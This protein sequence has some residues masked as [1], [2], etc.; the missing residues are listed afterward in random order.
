MNNGIISKILVVFGS[1]ALVIGAMF[2]V[3]NFYNNET[4]IITDNKQ[5]EK[6]DNSNEYN[7][8]V[9]LLRKEKNNN[10]IYGVLRIDEVEFYSILTKGADNK[11]YLNHALSGRKTTGGNPF[12]DYR[13][14]SLDDK[15][16]VVYG[17]SSNK[18]F[19]KLTKL[20]NRDT[21]NKEIEMKLYLEDEN[22]TYSLKFVKMSNVILSNEE[23][24]DDD[25]LT[26]TTYNDTTDKIEVE[27]VK[28]PVKEETKEETEEPEEEKEESIFKDLYSNNKY[29]KDNVLVIELI[30]ES[31]PVS[32][33][34]IIGVK[35]S[36]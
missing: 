11:Y 15:E 26:I 34:V 12:I 28:E 21:F 16:V 5:I 32:N 35:T 29:Y 14:I 9:K 33:M 17:S 13:N 1:L 3:I 25:S 10:E 20:F 19:S 31:S 30:N 7:V 24:I 4:S 23:L 18:E 6:K 27:E 22:A 36:K 8:N 2:L